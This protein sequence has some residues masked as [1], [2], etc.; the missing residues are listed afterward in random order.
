MEAFEEGDPK[1]DENIRSI[2]GT[3]QLAE[4]VQAC[5][6]AA[7]AEFDVTRQQ[8]LLKAA[9]YGKA[10]CPALDPAEFVTAAKTLRVLNSVRDPRVGLPLTVQQY[11]RLTPQALVGRLIVRNLHHLALRVCAFLGLRNDRVVVHWSA[12]KIR[13]AARSAASDAE[14]CE[15]IRSR[16]DPNGTGG[17]SYL[18]VATMANQMGRRRLA[19]MLLDLEPHAADQVPLLLSMR[20]EEMALQKAVD[21]GDTDLIYLT[22]IHLERSR[23]EPERFYRMVHAHPEAA[24]L[25]RVYYTHKVTAAER[26]PLQ[27][28][29]AWNRSHLEGGAAAASQ[30]YMQEA[31][32]QRQR[33]LREAASIF[34]QSRELQAYQKA[35]EEQ[36]DLL[37]AQQEL[38]VR[39]NLEFAGLGLN[40]TLH[41]LLVLAVE[42]PTRAQELNQEVTRLAR[43]FKVTDKA[44]YHI[45]IEA[46]A[47]CGQWGQLSRLANERRPPVG[48]KPFAQ[49][50]IRYG[51]SRG[52]AEMYIEKVT[53]LEQRFDLYTDVGSWQKAVDV[54]VKMRDAGRLSAA[55]KASGDAALMAQA[56]Q[57][58]S[59]W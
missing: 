23:L 56:R 34:S 47:R 14:L 4:A 24:A 35:T 37:D 10:F 30:A 19:T 21:A 25:L 39:A 54:A 59:K 41:N 27:G 32:P 36:A 29:L 5:L 48:F 52:A 49:A 57:L 58:V 8:A 44:L 18:E 16:M 9:S 3:N 40:A 26:E 22:L 2:E 38:E 31:H 42:E 50:C 11:S 15:L 13:R 43:K 53:P 7:Q 46:L 33:L 1:A 28:L 20:E 6:T 45:K 17:A 12:E 51:Q 55:A